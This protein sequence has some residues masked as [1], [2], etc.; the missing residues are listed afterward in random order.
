M[1]FLGMEGG[2]T[3]TVD[4]WN[5]PAVK[6]LDPFLL[7]SDRQGP[8]KN[9]DPNEVLVAHKPYPKLQQLLIVTYIV[10]PLENQEG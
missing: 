1:E 2:Y 7:A 4:E 6:G 8:Q 10:N 9:R 3:V 5:L